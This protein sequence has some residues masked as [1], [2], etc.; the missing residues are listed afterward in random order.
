MK[1]LLPAVQRTALRIPW[2]AVGGCA[3]A[4]LLTAAAPGGQYA[5]WALAAV[6]AA[7]VG[8]PGLL[9]VVCAGLGALLFMDFQPGLRHTAAA[10]LIFCANTALCNTRL[11]R[12]PRFR[13]MAAVCAA[14]L[15]QLPYLI[16]RGGRQW[17]LCMASLALLYGAAALLPDLLPESAAEQADKRRAWFLLLLGVCAVPAGWTVMGFSPAAVLTAVL[18]LYFV[19]RAP[20]PDAAAAGALAGLTLDL[21]GTG[22]LY[23]AVVLCAA[24]SAAAG[25]RS[26][27][28]VPAAAAFC[29]AGV[30]AALLLG[31]VRPLAVLCQ[32][33]T[34]AG[35]WLLLPEKEGPLLTAAGEVSPE[36]AA[37]AAAFRAVYDSLEDHAPLLRP[38]NPA[39]LFDRAAEQ[40]C[41]DCPLRSDC[42]QT[43]YTDT[44][45][46]FNDACP[47]LLRRGQALA[48]DFPPYFAA[49]CVR[50]PKLLGALD[51][52]LHD[53]LQR[54]LHHGRLD[55]A[56]RLAR[57]QYRQVAEVL[58]RTAPA[59]RLRRAH[60]TCRTAALLR[61]KTGEKH[62]GDQCAVFDAGGLTCLALSDGMGSGESA[63]CEA[64]M[65]IRLLRQFLQAGIEPLP[66]LKT[67]NTAAMLRCQ[68]GA[69][70]TTI[71]LA[72]LDRA[73]G[74][75]TLY[76]YGA[77]P[78]YIKRQ[79]AVA[80]YRAQALPAGLESADGDVPPQ[81]VA[82]SPGSWL[83]QVSDGVAGED[84]EWLQDLLAGWDG[85]SPRA[86]AEE[87]L[88]QSV[89]R[90]GGADDC[91]VPAPRLSDKKRR[92][93]LPA[94][95]YNFP[96]PRRY[97]GCN[98][99]RP[100]RLKEASVL[101]K[102]VSRRVI[103]VESPDPRIFEQAIFIL[104]T[105]GGG[106]S[107]RQ[108]VDE[109]VRIA[110]SY[111]RGQT[112]ARRRWRPPA[113]L[114]AVWGACACGLVWLLAA[115]L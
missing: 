92:E 93:I 61:P 32:L 86:L 45:N 77:A 111:A 35:V 90:T 11:Y 30:L 73:E 109:A 110:R 31:E 99:Q 107:S 52:Q 16:Q 23:L 44:Y 100:S 24:A 17:A 113:W 70:F 95:P 10:L 96:P 101:V 22:E 104:P 62:C 67:L 98:K 78:S 28:R 115:L 91:A 14:G 112:G 34:A 89:Q 38:E 18:L 27:Q 69:G 29:A 40:V 66:A 19:G 65:T 57:E 13:P 60:L 68:G 74:V 103:V 55:A 54:R 46:A 106:V 48:E 59:E 2:A 114:W 21:C 39:V 51:G 105:D 94:A 88:R 56:Y 82:V 1:H 58:S 63:H 85:T 4:L 97:Y 8:W 37:P 41:R 79:G 6:A 84:D 102:G 26:G 72:C 75:L 25:L 33:L 15:T 47:A 9:A 3:A 7:G 76:K 12:R 50:F 71:D 64:A 53:F 87:L 83:V 20:A 42:W 81:R 5:P 36:A 43:H 108:L 80:R 49:R